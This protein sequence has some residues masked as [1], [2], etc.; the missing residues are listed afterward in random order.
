MH[1]ARGLASLYQAQLGGSASAVDLVGLGSSVWV[2]LGLAPG[3]SLW[4]PD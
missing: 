4:D 2:G 3:R 1:I